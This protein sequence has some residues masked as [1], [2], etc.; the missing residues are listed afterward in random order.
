V[1]LSSVFAA[2]AAAKAD[3]GPGALT[4]VDWGVANATLEEVRPPDRPPAR[5]ARACRAPPCVRARP[6][7]RPAAVGRGGAAPGCPRPPTTNPAPGA[8]PPP[9]PHR[10]HPPPQVFIKFARSIG[11]KAGE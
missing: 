5:F 7:V 6:P 1:S 2:M 8:L 10:Q 9:P 11:A 3:A 4:I